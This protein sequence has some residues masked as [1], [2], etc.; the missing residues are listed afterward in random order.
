MSAFSMRKRTFLLGSA[1]AGLACLA[2]S[3]LSAA[4]PE[5]PALRPRMNLLLITADDLDWS[6][7]GFMGGRADLMPNLDA[8]A[9]R[10]HR[11]VNNRTVAPICMPSREAIMTGLVP[12]R[13]GGTGFTPIKPGIPTLTSV[14]RD[15]GYFAAAVHKVDH[16]LPYEAFQWDYIQ[17]SKDRSRLIQ[18]DGARVAIKEAQNGRKP[19]F[20]NCNSNDPHRPF[21]GSAAAA[22]VDHNQTGPYQ[23]PR[24]IGPAE[25]TIPPQLEDLPAIRVELAQYWNSVQ[26]LDLAIGHILQVLEE[27]G[28]ADNT[29]VMF[30]SDHGM[31]FPFAKAT[32]YDHGSR[33]PVLISWPGMGPPREITAQTTHMDI[34]PTVLD[35]LGL[36]SPEGIDGKS[37][38]PLMD[39]APDT[40]REFTVTHIN[41][42]SSGYAFPTRAIQDARYS[43]IFSPWADGTL[44]YRSES[45]IGLTFP[46]MVEAAKTDPRIAQ[47]VDQ[48]VLGMPMAFFDLQADPG[49]RTNLLKD[50]QHRARITR[51]TE[52]LL[53]EMIRTGDPELANLQTYL[54]GGAPVVPQ[55]PQRYRLRG[56][57]D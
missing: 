8:L 29:I 13:S 36:A 54:A 51:M 48:C 1:A 24:E 23:I 50:P 21:Y 28:E 10:S 46:A 3:S 5:A 31:P 33:V 27:S 55:D 52:L 57:G 22:V 56:G 38:V 18:A 37:W 35:L 16:M 17:Q 45:M 41:T 32:C 25:V 39:G 4:A 34:L 43:L 20:L 44:R 26:R 15:A 49:Q 40:G 47:R 2:P 19:F 7:P 53:A 42:L 11:F 30:C 6:L 12:H 14:L 9:S